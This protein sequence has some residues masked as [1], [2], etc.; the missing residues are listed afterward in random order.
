MKGG[1]LADNEGYDIL[2]NSEMRTFRDVWE[3]AYDA[4]RNLKQQSRHRQ[5]IVEI[6][7]RPTG[8]KQVVL[9]DGRLA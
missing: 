4:A 6:R 5:D 8:Q 1:V 9:E 3:S 2:I 7:H